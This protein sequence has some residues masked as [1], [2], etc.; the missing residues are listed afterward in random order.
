[1]F[2]QSFFLKKMTPYGQIYCDF[3]R[4][5]L[6]LNKARNAGRSRKNAGDKL[7]CGISPR[8]RDG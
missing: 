3:Q 2:S 7:K 8:L 6:F 4:F 1:M 5:L